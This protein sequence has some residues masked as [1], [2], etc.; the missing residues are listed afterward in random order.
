MGI[1]LRV[2]GWQFAKIDTQFIRRIRC[3]PK[4]DFSIHIW[5]QIVAYTLTVP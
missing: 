4:P 2:Y 3:L 5:L 1:T